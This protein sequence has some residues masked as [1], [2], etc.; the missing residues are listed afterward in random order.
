MER[1]NLGYSTKNIPIPSKEEYQK[2]LLDKTQPFLKRM[3]W[4]AL[5]FL[6]KDSGPEQKE[7]FGFK[8][9]RAPPHIKELERFE[10][11]ILDLIQK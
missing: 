4:K 3:R 5:F 1:T 8:S 10:S 11:R 7:T 2:R 6:N 9:R